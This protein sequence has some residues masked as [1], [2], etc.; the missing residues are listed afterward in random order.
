MAIIKLSGLT[1]G[2]L[3]VAMMVYGRDEGLPQDRIGQDPEPV[4]AS[5]L[6]PP[7]PIRAV[8]TPDDVTVAV[9]EA[10][11]DTAS[12]KLPDAQLIQAAVTTAVVT[13]TPEPVASEPLATSPVLYVTGSRVNMRA[14]PTTGQGIVAGLSHGT[15]VD[16]MGEAAPG[17]SQIRVI[18]TG[19][20]GFMATRFLSP[21]KP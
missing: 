12:D 15:A 16:D 9:A 13:V 5:V 21:D 14:G 11:V 19:Q 7:P 20:R 2:T 1:I 6:A 8:A 18:A 3:A 10:L 4:I 17:W